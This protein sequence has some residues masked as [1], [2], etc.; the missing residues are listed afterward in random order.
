MKKTLAVVLAAM[1]AASLTA[2]GGSAAKDTRPRLP[3]H[4]QQKVQQRKPEK[5][6]GQT[7]RKKQQVQKRRNNINLGLQ[8]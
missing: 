6:Q 2:C 3:K 1:M 5:V 7:K 4:R 8:K